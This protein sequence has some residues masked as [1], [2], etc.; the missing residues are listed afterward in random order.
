MAGGW[1]VAEPRAHRW[2]GRSRSGPSAPPPTAR[3]SAPPLSPHLPPQI[4]ALWDE[5]HTRQPWRAALAGDPL[6]PL[7]P[8]NDTAAAGGAGRLVAVL[9]INTGLGARAR[10][11]VLR[12][13]WVPTGSNLTA[14]EASLGVVIRFVVGYS[15]Q[16]DDPDERR[17]KQEMDA[18]GDIMRLDMVD[19]YADLSLKTLKLFTVLPQKWDADFYFKI[20]DDVGVNVPALADYL[21]SRRSQGNLYLGCMKSGQVL[22]DR[23]YKWYEPEWWRFGDPASAEGRINYM[24]HASGQAK[25]GG[26]G[27]GGGGGWSVNG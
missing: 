13:T 21:K 1:E 12:R 11:D 3:P 26:L 14:L 7:A 27:R 25:I 8:P 6:G 17:L 23:R 10:R 24:R 16:R 20:D 22:T 19:T 9:G 15:D 5:L 2:A 4:S 18:H